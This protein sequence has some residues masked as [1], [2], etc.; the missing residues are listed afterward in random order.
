MNE[1]WV[2][3]VS[4]LLVLAGVCAEANLLR[5]FIHNWAQ[6]RRDRREYERS[7]KGQHP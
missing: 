4:I 2:H 5:I 6:A 3:S 1:F 7:L